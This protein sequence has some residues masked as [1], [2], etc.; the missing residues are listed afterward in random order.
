MS[1]KSPCRRP[2]EAKGQPLSHHV[3]LK[4]RREQAA[5]NG[6]PQPLCVKVSNQELQEPVVPWESEP[7]SS[8]STSLVALVRAGSRPG[9]WMSSVHHRGGGGARSAVMER[10]RL[11]HSGSGH[12]ALPRPTVGFVNK[13]LLGRRC[14]LCSRMIKGCFPSTRVELGRSWMETVAAKPSR[15][16]LDL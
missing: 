12:A 6:L 11:T 1:Q 9:R 4:I 10:S 16:L 3:L 5:G 8:V 14:A 13:V 7:I 2:P 15:R